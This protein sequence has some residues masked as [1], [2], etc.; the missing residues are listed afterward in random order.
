M[1]AGDFAPL[2]GLSRFTPYQWKRR[3]VADGR[4]EENLFSYRCGQSGPT[5][6]GSC[7]ARVAISAKERSEFIE[8]VKTEMAKPERRGYD[9]REGQQQKHTDRATRQREALSA[10]LVVQG[11]LSYTRRR[12]PQPISRCKVT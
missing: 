9:A 8:A 2:L 3:F 6:A 4:A 5:P 7:Q 11:Y 12:I 1:P 10:A